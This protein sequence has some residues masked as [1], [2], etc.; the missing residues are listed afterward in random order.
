MLKRLFDI[1]ISLF[2][3][4]LFFPLLLII[5]LIIVLD[6]G[7]AI[8][9]LQNRV[10]KNNTDFDIIKFRTMKPG[11]DKKDYLPWVE[12]TLV[13]PEADYYYENIN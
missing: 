5:S 3:I 2:C 13:L 4:V 6:S 7:G 11:S 1:I 8:F 9:Y 12:M 10:G